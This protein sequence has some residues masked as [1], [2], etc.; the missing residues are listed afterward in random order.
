[1]DIAAT[2][3]TS[4]GPT[5]AQR[6]RWK[7]RNACTSCGS[8]SHWSNECPKN[9]GSSPGLA[10]GSSSNQKVQIRYIRAEPAGGLSEDDE[11]D[12]NKDY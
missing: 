4:S 10:R 2:R 7:K 11:G 12:N 9:D 1:M 3:V 8:P 6:K 5:E